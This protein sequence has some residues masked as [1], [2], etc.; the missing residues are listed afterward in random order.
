MAVIYT[1]PTKGTP[2]GAD[3]VLISDS[4]DEIIQKTL[5]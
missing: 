1:F 5:L 3:L 2:L 4:E